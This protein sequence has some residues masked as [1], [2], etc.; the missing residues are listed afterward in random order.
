MNLTYTTGIPD[1]PNNPSN[2]Q[3]IMKVNN[4]SNNTIWT[5]DHFGFNDNQGGY[6]KVIHQPNQTV[7]PPPISIPAP[8]NQIFSKSITPNTTGGVADTQLFTETALGKISQLTGFSTTAPGDGWQWIGGILLQWGFKTFILPNPVSSSGTIT[9]KDRVPGAIPFP[10][11]CFIVITT[12]FWSGGAGPT[13][14]SS[15]S[16]N[17]NTIT[18]TSFSWQY[19]TQVGKNSGF[20]WFA[21]GN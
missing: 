14:A 5:I 6:H 15:V 11:N 19:V 20:Y 13:T 9:F 12:T 1:A 2:D 7:N 8:I 18:N 16:I 3:P 4:D 17:D 21:L 10:T